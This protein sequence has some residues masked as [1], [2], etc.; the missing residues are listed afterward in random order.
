VAPME[1]AGLIERATPALAHAIARGHADRHS[2]AL[3]DDLLSAGHARPSRST[4]DRIAIELGQK[5]KAA[6]PRIETAL[7]RKEHVPDEARGVTV[8]LDRTTVPMAELG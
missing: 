2:R 5:V 6:M 8:G 4:I 7:R 3:H 1:S